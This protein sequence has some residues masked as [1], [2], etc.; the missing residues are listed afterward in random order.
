MK[1]LFTLPLIAL[2]VACGSQPEGATKAAPDKAVAAASAT[3]APAGRYAPR[4]DCAKL[5]GAEE[6]R[7]RLIEAVQL[8]DADAIAALADPAIKLDFGGSGGVA[9]LVGQLKQDDELWKSLDQV[10]KLGCAAD[11]HGNLVIPWLFAQDLGR[12]DANVALLVTGENVPVLTAPRASADKVTDISWDFVSA[13]NGMDRTKPYTQVTLPLNAH[14]YVA[15][16]KL[17]SVLDYRLLASRDSGQWRI[18]A[19]VR[20]D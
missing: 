6:C 17:R 4:D 8:R 10:L 1:H 13:A 14:G 18:G 11:P 3:P 16:D 5:P 19:L 7:Q 9:A 20:G 2:C 15:T 12:I